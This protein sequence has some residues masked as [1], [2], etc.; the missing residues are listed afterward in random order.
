MTETFISSLRQFGAIPEEDVP[1]ITAAFSTRAYQEGDILFRGGT[2]CRE[3]FIIYDGV[4]RVAVTGE[5]GNEVTL[6]F[7]R[8]H[9]ICTIL[10]SFLHQTVAEERIIA[11]CP[12]SVGVISKTQLDQVYQQ[13]PYLSAIITRFSHHLLMHKISLRNS[14]LTM[15]DSSGRYRLF[16]EKQSDV[17]LRVPLSSIASYLGITPQS[18]S[19]IR[20]NRS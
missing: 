7:I 13:L 6:F 9:A 8:E 16:L 20:R 14:Y 15:Q 12:V 10:E 17:A 5:A 4:L 1:L 3:M 18:L 19:R 2:V 11:A